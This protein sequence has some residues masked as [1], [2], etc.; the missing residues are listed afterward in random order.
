MA[1]TKGAPIPEEPANEMPHTPDEGGPHDVPDDEV[2]EQTLP[3]ASNAGRGGSA[4]KRQPDAADDR[5]AGGELHGGQGF[6]KQDR[7]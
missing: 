7:P 3:T 2:I 1:S 4:P 5:D 6:P